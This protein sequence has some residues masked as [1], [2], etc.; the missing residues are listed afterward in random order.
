MRIRTLLAAAL[1]IGLTAAGAFA[2]DWPNGPVKL[3]VPA[4]PGGGSD[5]MS[6]IYADYL[7]KQ[8]GSP[9]VVVNQPAGGGS[10]AFEELRNAAPDGQTLVF[11]HIGI[12]ISSHTGRYDHPISDFTTVSVAQAYPPQVLAV[13]PDA[14]WNSLKDFTDDAREHPGERIM[15][16]TLGSASHFIA[17]QIEQ[18]AGVK[19]KLVEASSEV[20]KVAAIQGGHIDIGNLG[21]GP[22]AQYVQAGDMKVL[23]L[24]T[25]DADPKYPDF[26]PAQAQGVDLGDWS[27][28]NIVWGP[29]GM[30]PALVE[31]INAALK[32]MGSDKETMDRLAKADS[33]F[34]YR[35][36]AASQKVVDGLDE[37][38]GALAKSLGF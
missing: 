6:R 10:V 7:Q 16:V 3:L 38:F 29:P 25:P 27:S 2:Q 35:D 26:I 17:G 12:I 18:S 13:A 4:K 19:L 14:P 33:S 36:V 37:R 5:I 22:A 23:A 1:T 15:G 30:D 9:V 28:P 11:Y 20:D 21:A 8:I 24:L 31:K 32:D 34:T